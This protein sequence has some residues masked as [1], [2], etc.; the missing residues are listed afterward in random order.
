MRLASYNDVNIYTNTDKPI[1]ITG[2]VFIG[3]P[4][5]KPLVLNPNSADSTTFLYGCQYPVPDIII[6]RFG[7]TLLK[8]RPVNNSG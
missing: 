1:L 6:P 5:T 7:S 4:V 8:N 3:S 2:D